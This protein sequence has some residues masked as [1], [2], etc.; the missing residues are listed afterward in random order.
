M[1]ILKFENASEDLP[2][3]R[4]FS[5]SWLIFG[6]TAAV[7]GIGTAFASST[8]NINGGNAIQIGQGVTATANCQGSDS[9]SVNPNSV[10]KVTDSEPKF[11]ISSIDLNNVNDTNNDDSTGLG[12]GG[13]DF[14]VQIWH[15]K[16]SPSPPILRPRFR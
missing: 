14:K 2:R 7:L 16:S 15:G 9:I 11:Y 3:S 4:K 8:I 6:G 13:L 5:K 12:C 1:E 10:L